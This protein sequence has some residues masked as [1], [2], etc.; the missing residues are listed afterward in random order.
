MIDFHNHVLP[1]VDD[2]PKTM[3]ESILMIK[4]ASDQG[5]TDVVQTVHFQHPKMDGKDT[6][7]KFLKSEISK[8]QN[9]IDK[10]NIKIKMHLS[11]EVFYLPNLVE[12][13]DNP[14]VTIGNKKYMLIEFTTNIFPNGYEDQFY[15][16]QLNGITPI[17]AH[18]ERYRFIQSD[19]SLLRLWIERGYIIQ[20]DAGS[21]IGNFGN[22]TRKIALK[23][24][25][26]N[27]I[28]VVG[29]DSHNSKKRN[30]CLKESYDK[31]ES[32]KSKK[33]VD[34][35]QKNSFSILNGGKICKIQEKRNHSF[36]KTKITKLYNSI[37]LKT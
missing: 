21:I 1:N 25:D 7:Y 31:I 15:N 33:Y 32:I 20:I 35:L 5:I 22:H 36:I 10:R 3:D 28:H 26:N 12:I 11:A 29:S 17:V 30:F 18:P 19:I 6:S 13:S 9:E 14:L 27:Y 16:L 37:W 2:G 23:M 8:F 34:L 4:E 24:L